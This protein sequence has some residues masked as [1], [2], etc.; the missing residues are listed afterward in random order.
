MH[1]LL[2]KFTSVPDHGPDL[3]AN[4]KLYQP[5]AV[6]GVSSTLPCHP[7]LSDINESQDELRHRFRVI[8]LRSKSKGGEGA[9][10][11]SRRHDGNAFNCTW[12]KT[13]PTFRVCVHSKER[14]KYI[15]AALLSSGI[16]EPFVTIIF[17][18]ALT[19]HP[20]AAVIDIGANI[21]YY[22]LLAAAM[23]HP[24]LAVEPQRENLRRLAEA[25]R[26]RM[27][28][29]QNS[30]NGS[31]EAGIGSWA[32]GRILL[33]AN[34]VSDG[35][36][37]VSLTTSPDNQGEVRVVEECESPLWSLP[38]R[39]TGWWRRR[40]DK[41]R[42]D[43]GHAGAQPEC[44]V[45]TLTMD[46]LLLAV[47]SGKVIIKVDI[48]GYECR[49]L[50]TARKFFSILQVPYIL[51]EWRQMRQRQH[52]QHTDCTPPQILHLARFLANR[53]YMPHEVRSGV[54]LDPG[55]ASTWMV[56]DV[57]WRAAGQRLLTP[58]W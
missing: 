52:H 49:A 22:T 19:L 58:A 3:R 41:P 53:G 56:G 36:R 4:L 6:I 48:E 21:G 7:H 8:N 26:P 42:T 35:H 10:A 23:G 33:L 46:D 1:I 2:G 20:D 14:D 24:V 38:G 16:W 5:R 34:A 51:M 54:A 39:L 15:S 44:D 9:V 32:A 29:W 40:R 18:Q 55:Q 37:N 27:R 43:R 13:T 47:P 30:K 28:N 17:Q 57:Y 31:S 12:S 50:A 45:I 11:S 25:A